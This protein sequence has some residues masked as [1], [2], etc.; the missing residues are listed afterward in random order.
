MKEHLIHQF[1]LF[2]STREQSMDGK[3]YTWLDM[4]KGIA[5]FLVVLGHLGYIPITVGKW[6]SSF[7]LPLF[8]V[9]SGILLYIKRDSA[10]PVR[11]VLAR[12]ARGILVPYLWFSLGSVALLFARFL[13]HTAERQTIM[14]AALAG[15]TFQGYSVL[16]F[17]PVT[18]G[19]EIIVILLVRKIHPAIAAGILTVA[20]FAV[21][22]LYGLVSGTVTGSSM[23]AIY[24]TGYVRLLG[25]IL[26]AA[27]FMTYAYLVA[28]CIMK[29]RRNGFSIRQTGIGIALFAVNIFAAP[30]LRIQDLN[31]LAV[32]YLSVYLVL[33]MTGSVGL[34]LL[35]RNC[36]NIPPITFFGQNSLIIMCTH[37]N[38]YVMYFASLLVMRF[39]KVMPDERSTAYVLLTM[40][41][42]FLLSIP[43]ILFINC[44]FPF[45]LG[46]KYPRKRL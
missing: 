11:S 24:L 6:L 26:I 38:F 2:Y 10:L 44:F 43:M 27:A 45:V 36:T 18:F 33:G 19:A 1:K 32:D 17:L 29:S 28:S 25:K 42:T 3:R 40:L 12:T 30:H 14:D 41:F 21:F 37:M 20:A 31:N 35:C 46:R 15:I 34:I 13:L 39:G 9:V 5:I 4:A 7:H 8:F 16:W 22:Y 23:I